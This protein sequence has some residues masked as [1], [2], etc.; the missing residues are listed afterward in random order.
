M[1]AIELSII[2]YL[3][4]EIQ[5]ST[6]NVIKSG[7]VIEIAPGQFK[8]FDT[9]AEATDFL[10]LPK[11]KEAFEKLTDNNEILVAWLMENEDNVMDAF[12]TGSIKRVTK[13][14][15]KKLSKALDSLSADDK[16]VAFLVENKA[17]ILSSFRWPSVKRLSPEE[18]AV[19]ITEALTALTGGNEGLV[20]WLATNEEAIGLAYEAGK[21][22]R[23]VN[24]KAMAALAAMREKKQAEK[25]ARLAAEEAA[26]DPATAPTEAE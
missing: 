19:A 23:E 6:T 22:T 3:S 5:M 15:R 4:K 8:V 16:T 9:K 2:I 18:R 12:E 24:P 26:K 21:I 25:A 20:A 7:H 17:E 1:K 14:D 10:R 13:A 11:V